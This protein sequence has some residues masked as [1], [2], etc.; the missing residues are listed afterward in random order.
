[1]VNSQIEQFR[2]RLAP[3]GEMLRFKR[4]AGAE[5]WRYFQEESTCPQNFSQ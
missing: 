3:S 1:M 5:N 2:H 4:W